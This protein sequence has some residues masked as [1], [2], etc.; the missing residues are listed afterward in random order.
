[1]NEILSGGYRSMMNTR[2]W[3]KSHH[4][5]LFPVF[6]FLK[7][8]SIN[9][10]FDRLGEQGG[11]KGALYFTSLGDVLGLGA[12]VTG[13]LADCFVNHRSTSEKYIQNGAGNVFNVQEN[14]I[15]VLWCVSQVQYGRIDIEEPRRRW[16][17]DPLE[18]FARTIKKCVDRGEIIIEKNIIELTTEGM[19]WANTIGAEMAVE[20]L[21]DGKGELL[22][23]EEKKSKIAKEIMLKKIRSR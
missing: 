6:P 12:G 7:K 8:K 9:W 23:L 1:M 18:A 20:C 3:L 4:D 5:T 22:S 10:L 21:Y 11:E 19:F 2:K 13:F 14:I 17:L 16:G 15:P